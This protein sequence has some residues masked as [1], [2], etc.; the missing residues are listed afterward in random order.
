MRLCF[1]GSSHAQQHLSRA[2]R[3][4]GFELCG[5]PNADLVFVSQDTPTNEDGERDLGV[6]RGWLDIA[7]QA[8]VPIVLTSAVPPGFTRSLGFDLWH[9]AE[10]LRIRDAEERALYPEMLIVGGK[11]MP[12]PAGAMHGL[13]EIYV[14]YLLAFHCPVLRMTWEEAEFAK[15]A[16]NCTLAAQVENTNR[17]SAAARKIGVRWEVIADALGLDSRIG[18]KSYLTPGRWQ[19]SKHLTRDMRT[20][21]EIEE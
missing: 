21:R 1:L 5:S 12:K 20:L 11:E 2:A 17:L 9:Q 18:A 19:D 7:R 6:I 8:G 15:L 4:K 14:R 10:T 16:I 13:P 3:A